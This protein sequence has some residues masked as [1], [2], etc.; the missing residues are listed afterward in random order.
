MLPTKL[1]TQ[2]CYFSSVLKSNNMLKPVIRPKVVIAYDRYVTY[3]T[4]SSSYNLSHTFNCE[5]T[6]QMG[7]I[8]A[9]RRQFWKTL[10]KSVR[11]VCKTLQTKIDP[12]FSI[13]CE[14]II[15]LIALFGSCDIFHAFLRDTDDSRVYTLAI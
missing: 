15:T 4:L 14:N 9:K 1:P 10:V 2:R 7:H 12:N 6:H 11:F 5:E 8:L 3:S 13:C